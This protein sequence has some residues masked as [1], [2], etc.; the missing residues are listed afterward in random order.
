[1]KSEAEI[2][3]AHKQTIEAF[4]GKECA[5]TLISSEEKALKALTI[6]YIL[7]QIN[8]LSYFAIEGPNRETETCNYRQIFCLLATEAG[9]SLKQIAFF[10]TN[11][12]APKKRNHTTVLYN[13]KTA[14]DRLQ[15]SI[16]FK[17][18]YQKIKK[19]IIPK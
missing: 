5:I 17:H 4:T 6:P 2:L 14:K 15:N 11:K 19:E 1:M 7:Q 9:Y 12:A 8:T 13:V 3:Q 10:L 16:E 18:L